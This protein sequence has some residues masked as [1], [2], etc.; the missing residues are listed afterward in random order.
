[1]AWWPMA[2]TARGELL[3]V[4]EEGLAPPASSS[5]Y[6][7]CRCGCEKSLY[8]LKAG[9]RGGRLRRPS[10]AEQ[11]VTR[12]ACCDL[13]ICDTGWAM[14]SDTNLGRSLTCRCIELRRMEEEPS[15]SVLPVFRGKPC[16]ISG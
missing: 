6:L 10:S 7:R 5:A 15:R 8:D 4:K 11:T 3:R 16:R 1:M 14:Y 13:L 12:V 9:P 2:S